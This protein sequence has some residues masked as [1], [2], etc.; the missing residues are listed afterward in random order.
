MKLKLVL[1]FSLFF[2]IVFSQGEANIWYFGYN[3]G[4]DFNSGSPVALTNGQLNTDEGC[5]TLSNAVGQLLFYTDGIT[6]YNKNHQVMLNGTGLMGHSS[7]TQSATI[8]PK[9]GSSTLFYVFTI[10]VEAHPNGFRY[11]IIDLTLDGGL[12]GVTS[13]KNV[14]IYTPTCEKIAVIKHAN[15]TDYWIVTH[16]F[17]NN[18]YY[19]HLLTNSGLSNTAVLSNVGY[20]PLPS[21]LSPNITGSSKGYLKISPNGSKLAV[22]HSP[23]IGSDTGVVELCDFNNVT[24]VIS[25]PLTLIVEIG[26]MYGVEFSPNSEVLYY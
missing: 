19:A 14:L 1:L 9:P 13:G 18:T 25:N 23:N 22:V 10:D 15:N 4:L 20:T 11:S 17:G 7:T 8:V 6:V 21:P 5:A 26:E 24:G 2:N 12:G 3:A 16:G